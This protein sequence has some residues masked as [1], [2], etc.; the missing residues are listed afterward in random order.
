MV[1]LRRNCDD[2]SV[3]AAIAAFFGDRLYEEGLLWN[4]NDGRLC[5]ADNRRLKLGKLCIC[6]MALREKRS[7]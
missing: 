4:A 3:F 1:S 5:S 2:D 6:V 7:C